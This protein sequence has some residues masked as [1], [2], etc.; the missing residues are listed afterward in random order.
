M[1]HC[2]DYLWPMQ[3]VPDPTNVSLLPS[4]CEQ[5]PAPIPTIFWLGKNPATQGC[6]TLACEQR[7]MVLSQRAMVCK[8]HLKILPTYSKRQG[9]CFFLVGQSM[10]AASRVPHPTVYAPEGEDFHIRMCQEWH[11]DCCSRRKAQPTEVLALLKAGRQLPVL[12]G[13]CFG[14][15]RAATIFPLLMSTATIL[16][17]Q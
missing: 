10:W 17:L 4:P 16:L 1:T 9:K 3:R 11:Q 13:Y 6:G 15:A 7:L 8:S 5:F 14:R 12:H 2:Q